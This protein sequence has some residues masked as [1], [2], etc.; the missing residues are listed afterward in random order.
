M[1][2]SVNNKPFPQFYIDQPWQ[3]IYETLQMDDKSVAVEELNA[4]IWKSKRMKN[5]WLTVWMNERIY[6]YE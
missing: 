1:L 4:P 2:I 5:D 6:E 3:P